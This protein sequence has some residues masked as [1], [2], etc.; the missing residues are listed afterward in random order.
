MEPDFGPTPIF[1]VS[2]GGT[3]VTGNFQDRL[4]EINLTDN[5]GKESDEITLKVDDRD[6]AVTLPQRGDIMD[7]AIGYA[8]SGLV[9]KGSFEVSDVSGSGGTDGFS[10]TVHGKSA[11][12][13]DDQKSQ[14]QNAY[15]GKALPDV[16]ND[17]AQRHGLQASVDSSFSDLQ[18]DTLNQDHESDWHILQRLSRSYDATFAVKNGTLIFNQASSGNNASGQAM[19]GIYLEITDLIEYEFHAGDRPKHKT[20]KASWYD[21]TKG[22]RVHEQVDV[23][24]DGATATHHVRHLH[25]NQAHAQRAA[26]GKSAK[27]QRA[28]A[29][30][31]VTITG[32]PTVTAEGSVVLDTGRTG[33]DGEW[34]VKTVTHTFNAEGYVTKIAAEAKDGVS[35]SNGNAT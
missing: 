31:T 21:R 28:E 19:P 25:Y 14:R 3:D 9:D 35:S 18:W 30:I 22:K 20:V 10:I 11:S 4:I 27:L 7:V 6:F 23:E 15:Q 24:E 12:Q 2:V 5:A 13:V 8:E 34:I 33:L 26:K 32:D 1:S 29:N 16:V 17:I